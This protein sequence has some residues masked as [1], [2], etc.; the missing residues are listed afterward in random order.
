MNK[1][2]LGF[3]NEE[4]LMAGIAKQEEVED[5]KIR[6]SH[7]YHFTPETPPADKTTKAVKTMTA[8]TYKPKA[9]KW[10]FTFESW[11]AGKTEAEALKLADITLGLTGKLVHQAYV[12][13]KRNF[14]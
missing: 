11:K 7:A 1:L 14:K 3:W 8:E 10:Q 5:R 13:Y 4:A 2:N 9:A 12:Y 6:F